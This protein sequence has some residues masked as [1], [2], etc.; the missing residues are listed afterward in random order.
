MA[1]DT[2]FVLPFPCGSSGTGRMKSYLHPDNARVNRAKV[3]NMICFFI[4]FF[5]YWTSAFKDIT[6]SEFAADSA[7][8]QI[9]Y[10]NS[11]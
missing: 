9:V 3:K 11:E 7:V 6:F 10:F 8:I 5:L 1:N 2:G 4:P